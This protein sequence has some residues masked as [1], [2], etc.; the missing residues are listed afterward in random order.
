MNLKYDTLRLRKEGQSYNSIASKLLCSKSTVSYH[1]S[2]IES[3]GKQIETLNKQREVARSETLKYKL[4]ELSDVH[5]EKLAKLYESGISPKE[6]SEALGCS[7]VTVRALIKLEGITKRYEKMSGYKAVTRRNSRMKIL[8]VEYKG[9]ECQLCGYNRCYAALDFH[10][11]NLH[12]KDFRISDGRQ[13][14]WERV[15]K[16]LDKCVCLCSNCHREVHAGL[17]KVDDL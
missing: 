13:R 16:E 11:I 1:C 15:R 10:H 17:V 2:K 4:V 12:S 8:S 3:N 6:I 7:L 14:S 5:K 9:G